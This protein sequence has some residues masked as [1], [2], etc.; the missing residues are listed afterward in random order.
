MS[1]DARNEM[2]S[3]MAKVCAAEPASK[4]AWDATVDFMQMMQGTKMVSTNDEAVAEINYC[5]V[6]AIN[7][8]LLLMHNG[9]EV[10]DPMSVVE[11]IMRISILATMQHTPDY[12]VNNDTSVN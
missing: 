3:L 2:E 5:T 8:M 4:A 10:K 6:H 12:A 9:T 1:S 11:G 7:T